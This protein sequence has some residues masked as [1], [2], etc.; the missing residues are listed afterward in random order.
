LGDH[1]ALIV[2]LSDV[3]FLDDT[4]A[5]TIENLIKDAQELDKQVEKQ[6]TWLLD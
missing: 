2:D 5:L 4:I 1:H 6:S 3:S